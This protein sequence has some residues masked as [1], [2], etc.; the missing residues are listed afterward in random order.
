MRF[1]VLCVL[2]G[3]GCGILG[4]ACRTTGGPAQ[5]DIGPPPEEPAVDPRNGYM[6]TRWIG[7]RSRSSG[8][9]PKVDGW[10]GEPLLYPALAQ[11]ALIKELGL[12]RFCVYTPHSGPVQPFIPP[13]GLTA[14]RDRLAISASAD[15]LVQGS[16]LVSRSTAVDG[17]LA[18]EFLSQAGQMPLLPGLTSGSPNVQITVLD[19]Q[20]TGSLSAPALPGSQH[21]FAVAQLARKLVCNSGSNACAATV[22]AERALSYDDPTQ[23]TVPL[24][25]NL[26][27]SIGTISDLGLAI[28]KAVSAS[29]PSKHLILNLSI[30]WDGETQLDRL[31]T[32][33][34]ARRVAQLDPSVQIVHQALR[35]AARKGVLVIAAAGN[36]RGGSLEDSKWPILPAAW[37]LRRPW[38]SL[39][40]PP[41]IYAVGGVDWQGLPLPNSRTNG[42]PRRVA[43]GDHATAK[44]NGTPTAVYTGTS[45]SAAV[46]SATAA[47]IWHLRPEL[48]PAKVME[49]IDSSGE[50]QEARADFYPGHNSLF[51]P[52]AP[53]IQE[54][55]LCA[56]VKKASAAGTALLCP[57]LQHQPPALSSLL[58]QLGPKRGASFSPASSPSPVA[59][60]CHPGT[61]L[62][63][64]GGPVSQ[65][66]CP[67]DQYGSISAQPWVLPQPG[68]TPCPNCTLVP[69]GPPHGAVVSGPPESE[70]FTRV[71]SV[72]S[73]PG[74]YYQLAIALSQSWLATLPKDVSLNVTA[75]LDI[76]RFVPGK[77]MKRM[78]YPVQIDYQ[79]STAW[80]A[81]GFGDG[82]SLKGCR[83]QLNFVVKDAAGTTLMSVQ[84]PV[85]VDP[86]P[87]DATGVAV[88][89]AGPGK[90]IVAVST[91]GVRAGETER[92]AT[93]PPF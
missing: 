37:E 89:P 36:R 5:S 25:S 35:L 68:D 55:S 83:A 40:D 3:V 1:K 11:D 30:G 64:A 72:P 66:V 56:A 39:F 93:D 12:D 31:R 19:S 60:P 84:N 74:L 44:V 57:P 14:A 70:T 22:R 71:S 45:V 86:G 79:T 75:M 73:P 69:T 7:L 82:E 63:T 13:P 50:T 9:C 85:V 17:A 6:S 34:A 62:L 33:L 67:T 46:V 88:N 4:T 65:P 18:Q 42:L 26:P 53:H 52:P 87:N 38:P 61:L 43:Y 28:I 59:P 76:D 8:R 77:P 58:A 23:T 16:L 90:N 20:P 48:T 80:T 15:S 27:G 78:T 10:T 91:N 32:D 29:S 47:V 24:P 41:L 54:I 81:F 21:G 92:R 2:L 49:L 51:P